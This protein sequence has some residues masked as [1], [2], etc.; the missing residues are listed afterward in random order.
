LA[1]PPQD[2]HWIMTRAAPSLEVWLEQWL[3]EKW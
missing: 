2:E 1:P 3:T